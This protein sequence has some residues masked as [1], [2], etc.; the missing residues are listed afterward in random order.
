MRK[1]KSRVVMGALL[2]MAIV[3]LA[4]FQPWLSKQERIV[5]LVRE[6]ETDLAELAE[7]VRACEGIEG[8][9]YV[10]VKEITYRADDAAVEFMCYSGATTK[11]F[12]Y[13][14][15][16]EPENY[17]YTLPIF[18]DWYYFEIEC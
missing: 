16:G 13:A 6:N 17:G 5:R 15:E 7:V 9:K 4:M 8:L 12:C 3:C 18:G 1:K 10:G 14:P 2:F 11:G